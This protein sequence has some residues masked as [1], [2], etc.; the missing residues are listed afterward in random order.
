MKKP[1][2][3][4]FLFRDEKQFELQNPVI[5]GLY[6]QLQLRTSDQKKILKT[7]P[8]IRDLKIKTGLDRLRKFNLARSSVDDDDNDDDNNIPGLPPAVAGPS[9][10]PRSG[11]NDDDDNDDGDDDNLN[12]MQRFLLNRPNERIAEA[13]AES[14]AGPEPRKIAFSK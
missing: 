7:A 5:G 11:N 2:A 10:Q 14:D 13:I 3:S 4:N 6:N 12:N 8:S 9:G 1:T